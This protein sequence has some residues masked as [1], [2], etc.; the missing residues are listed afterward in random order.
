MSKKVNG[1]WGNA[2]R[3]E[4]KIDTLQTKLII[5]FIIYIEFPAEYNLDF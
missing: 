1:V 2:P 5:Q 4:I 3:Y